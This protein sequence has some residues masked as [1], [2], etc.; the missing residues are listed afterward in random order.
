[1]VTVEVGI[2]EKTV[3]EVKTVALVVGMM[4]MVAAILFAV[5]VA[6]QKLPKHPPGA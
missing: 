6:S 2:T 4:M 5:T 1:M 3:V